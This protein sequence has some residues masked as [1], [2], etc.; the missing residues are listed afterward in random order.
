MRP[1][2][3]LIVFSSPSL[4]RGPRDTQVYTLPLLSH[5]SLCVLTMI[6][7]LSFLPSHL[8]DFSEIAR[9][10]RQPYPTVAWHALENEPYPFPLSLLLGVMLAII[11]L[12]LSCL[13]LYIP[14]WLRRQIGSVKHRPQPTPNDDRQPR[15]VSEKITK[16]AR[17]Y[18]AMQVLLKVRALPAFF[19]M[20]RFGRSN[21]TSP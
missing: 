10:R 3:D 18:R 1:P 11:F 5:G 13:A 17:R 15:A 9:L 4:R 14:A 21:E 6:P 12:R 16:I 20:P 8:F 19:N 2:G 7:V